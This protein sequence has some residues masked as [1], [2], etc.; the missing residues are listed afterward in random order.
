M[1]KRLT[2]ILL[3]L[4]PLAAAGQN[5]VTDFAKSLSD[6]CATFGYSYSVSGQVPLSGSG[7]IRLQGD[8]FTMQ[9]DGLE[10]YCDGTTRWTLDTAAEECYIEGV[11]AGGL[12]YEANPALL[13]GAVDKAFKLS[14]TSSRTF[15]GTKVTEAVLKPVSKDGNITE[16][17]LMMT[18]AKKP[19]GLIVKTSDGNTITVIVK[20]FLIG[21]KAALKDFAFDTG[22]LGSGYIVTDLR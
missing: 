13:V 7:D 14:G 17:S 18:T 20:D 9:G 5:I 12:D 19:A 10:V 6:G 1:M 22:K 15:N 8:A 4:F 3:V 21:G 16:L 11:K 2:A